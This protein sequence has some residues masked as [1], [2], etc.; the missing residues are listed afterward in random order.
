[1]E[2]E[3][4]IIA[5]QI[6]CLKKTKIAHTKVLPLDENIKLTSTS[7]SSWSEEVIKERLQR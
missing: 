7:K 2:D 1:M 4:V 6:K 3:L 5:E